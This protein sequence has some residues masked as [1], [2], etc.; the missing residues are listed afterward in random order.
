MNA[1]VAIFF[2]SILFSNKKLLNLRHYDE[3]V[4]LQKELISI[5][6]IPDNSNFYCCQWSAFPNVRSW[7]V[8]K[9]HTTICF[10]IKIPYRYCE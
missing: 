9:F 7:R 3:N 8:G 10:A 5:V 4:Q 2:Q 1:N 6:P